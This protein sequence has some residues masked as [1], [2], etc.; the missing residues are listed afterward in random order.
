M[1][2][3]PTPENKSKVNTFFC[4]LITTFWHDLTGAF[5]PREWKECT[6]AL[7]QSTPRKM[8]AN[9]MPVI[10]QLVVFYLVL[11]PRIAM[12]FYNLLLFYPAKGGEYELT[13]IGGVSKEDCFFPS[14]NGRKLHGWYFSVPNARGTVIISHGNAN[15]ITLRVPLIEMFIHSKVSVFIYDY[16][17]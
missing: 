6:R 16:Q 17:G 2:S 3:G 7:H 4:E 15:N 11:A 14:V 8:F 9:L 13:S 12:P 5:S 1:W 10:P